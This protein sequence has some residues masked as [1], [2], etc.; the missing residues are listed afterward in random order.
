MENEHNQSSH[1]E[2]HQAERMSTPKRLYR[3]NKNKMFAGVCGGLGEYFDIDAT[4]LRLAWMF[5][6]V[7]T[8]FFPGILVYIIAALIIPVAPRG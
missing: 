1:T 8:G 3:S 6:V 4:L 5:F 7:F 2:F